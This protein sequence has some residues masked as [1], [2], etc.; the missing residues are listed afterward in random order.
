[1]TAIQLYIFFCLLKSTD[2]FVKG[3]RYCK[4]PSILKSHSHFRIFKLE[5]EGKGDLRAA[6]QFPTYNDFAYFQRYRWLYRTA[7]HTLEQHEC[8]DDDK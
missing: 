2:N 5:S 6:A 7:L 8:V 1:M 3:K 4:F